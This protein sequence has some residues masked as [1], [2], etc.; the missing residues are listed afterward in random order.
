VPKKVAD[1]S[2]VLRC[3]SCHLSDQKTSL[4]FLIT[5]FLFEDVSLLPQ[6]NNTHPEGVGN[7]GNRRV[8]PTIDKI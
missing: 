2:T 8:K 5:E 3:L 4:K 6:G 1:A 7:E